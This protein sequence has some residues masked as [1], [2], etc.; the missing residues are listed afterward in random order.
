[1]TRKIKLS[2]AARDLDISAQEI[3]DFFAGKGREK[4]TASILTPEEMDQVL[5]YLT[6]KNEVTSFEA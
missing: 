1:M 6:R 5:E 4:K 2:D 3:I